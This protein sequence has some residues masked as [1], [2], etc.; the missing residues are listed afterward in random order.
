MQYNRSRTTSYSSGYFPPGVKWLLIANTAIFLLNFFAILL[1]EVDP[2]RA[3]GLVPYQVVTGF[4]AWQLVTYM[5]LHGGVVHIL[6]NMLALWMFGADLER[7]WGTD[8]FLKY[9]F[10]C[11]VGAGISVIAASLLFGGA[12]YRTIG[13]SGAIYGIL[14][15]FGVLYPDRIVLFSFLFPMKAKYFVLITGA[16]VFLNSLQGG[17]RVSHVAH[18]G[19]MV[20]GYIFL[21]LRFP[22]MRMSAG[23][24]IG[25]R[26]RKWK[27]DRA[28]RKFQVYMRRRESDRDRWVH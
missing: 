13:A 28:R 19:G 5:F 4:Y 9:Y 12:E 7:D 10:L 20:F 6:F 27:A 8:R 17:S 24:A 16:I 26:Y 3:F 1:F 15:A 23:A 11:G 2:F 21:K 18:L 22:R 25:Q 14:L